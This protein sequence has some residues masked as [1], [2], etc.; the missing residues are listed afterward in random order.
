M[1]T[2]LNNF[3]KNLVQVKQYCALYDLIVSNLPTLASQAESLLR[4]EW[5]MVVSNFDT[6]IHDI[7]RIALIQIF[8]G[9][10]ASNNVADAYTLSFNTLKRIDSLTNTSDKEEALEIEIRKINE[11]DSYQ[12]PKNIEYAMSLIGISGIWTKISPLLGMS[13]QD[14]KI[15]LGL[16]V[17]RR[18]KIAHESD[19]DYLS[20]AQI[21]ITK[22][23]VDEVVLFIERLVNAIHLQL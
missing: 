9:T 3:N 12:S 16:I 15:K 1:I 7:V 6:Y 5:V 20:S 4:A 8:R 13:P 23:D 18:N 11:K 2:A 22:D 14:I 21:A 10:R 17:N 19:Y